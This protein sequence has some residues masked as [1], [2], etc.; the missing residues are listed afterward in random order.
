MMS[1]VRK[2]PAVLAVVIIA[3]LAFL[4]V[5]TGEL[6]CSAVVDAAETF[7]IESVEPGSY[8]W[9]LRDGSAPGGQVLVRQRALQFERSDL[10]E[11]SLAPALAT[12][13]MVDEGQPVATVCSLRAGTRLSEMRSQRDSLAAQRALLAAGG[14]PEVVEEAR[15]RVDV[16]EAVVASGQAEL[17]R[18]RLLAD[19]GLASSGEL[20]V[21]ELEAE[22][23]RLGVELAQSMVEVAKGPARPQSLTEVDARLTAVDAGIQEL[24]RLVQEEQVLSPIQGIAGLGPPGTELRVDRLDTVYLDIPIPLGIG[25]RVQKDAEVL[26]TTSAIPGTTFR[27]VLV[28]LATG[29]TS[30]QGRPVIWASAR[31]DN[32]ELLLRPGMV[33]TAYV[34]V[35]GSSLGRMASLKRK[36]FGWMP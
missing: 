17:A 36:L 23:D 16:A 32:P 24:Q 15:R 9:T 19:K 21:A 25:S 27:S 26:F 34:P 18:L 12:G 2:A 3:G 4:A 8:R 7:S 33:G 29:A 1:G 10:V 11:M 35:D 30:V 31:I 14:A 6:R 5:P 22:I 28:E 13:A 20:E